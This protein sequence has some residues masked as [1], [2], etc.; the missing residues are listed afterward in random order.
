MT[1]TAAS[2]AGVVR[3]AFAAAEQADKEALFRV[4]RPGVE[5]QLVGMLPDRPSFY[6]GREEVWAAARSLAESVEDP[7]LELLDVEDVGDHAVAQVHLHGRSRASGD[8]VD[9]R[10]SMLLKV[11]D[12]RI[13]RA[14]NYEDHDEA[15]T[16]AE[17]RR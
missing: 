3:A 1:A 4:L 12:G 16:D 10:F 9:L 7:V 8:P 11:Q 5:W 6:R 14:D 15:L 17:L 13:A 2:P